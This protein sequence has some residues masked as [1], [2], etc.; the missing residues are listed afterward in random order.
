MMHCISL[1][2]HGTQPPASDIWWT[3]LLRPVQTSLP[4]DPPLPT[5]STDIW[6]TSLLRPVQTSSPV[7][8]P[9]PTTSTDIWW[10]PK[11]VRLASG[12][13]I[14]YWNAFLLYIVFNLLIVNMRYLKANCMQTP[15]SF[16]VDYLVDWTRVS[17]VY[18]R[19]NVKSF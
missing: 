15:A 13:Y 19:I 7:D 11:H 10:P 5:T 2:R 18:T 12:R 14:S 8:P 17:H 3:S 4:V 16:N 6:W 1:Y 9:L